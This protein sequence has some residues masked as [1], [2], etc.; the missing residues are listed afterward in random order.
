MTQNTNRVVRVAT[1]VHSI[2]RGVVVV[3]EPLV[4]HVI[5]IAYSF[6]YI[7]NLRAFYI[8][9]LAKTMIVTLLYFDAIRR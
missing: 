7:S 5:E 9:L 4:H 6:I 3:Y 1:G 2:L 8:L